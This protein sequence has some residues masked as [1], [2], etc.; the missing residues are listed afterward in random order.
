V[1]EPL[2]TAR[3]SVTGVSVR[4]DRLEAVRD[5]TFDLEPG[6]VTGL[7]G[8]NGAGKTT[9]ID[10]ISGYLPMTGDVRLD[11]RSITADAPHARARR[12]L[13]RTFQSLELFDD[14]SVGENLRLAADNAGHGRRYDDVTH[15]VGSAVALDAMAGELAESDRRMVALARAAAARPQVLLADEPGAGLDPTARDRVGQALRALA[16]G[17]TA[18]LLVDHDTDLVF[19][20][21][22]RVLVLDLGALVA[23][24]PP[25]AVRTDPRV[26]SAY[27]GSTRAAAGA[28]PP[29]ARGDAGPPPVD[30][31][32]LTA[33]YGRGD[34]VHGIDLTITSGEIVALLGPNGAGKTTTLLALSGAL[35]HVGGTGAV[36]GL[37]LGTPAHRSARHG[38]AHVLQDRGVFAGLT[39]RENLRLAQR[40]RDDLD[41][42]V[43]LFPALRAA[44]DRRAGSLSGGEQQMLALA[45]ALVR[46]PR[47]LL[48]DELSLGL[49]PQVVAELLDVVA[50]LARDHGTAVLF[51]EQH[52][53]V[54]LRVAHRALVLSRGTVFDEGPAAAF[55]DEPARLRT[56]Y[57]GRP[58]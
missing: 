54:A 3:L 52:A 21:C 12:G 8:P 31:R 29:A 49:A 48:V 2:V 40:R 50:G 1:A 45:R 24:G 35:R 15:L 37:P 17:G 10:A 22:D 55:R 9:L 16:D 30:V 28:P 39:T 41:T 44:L 51:A 34:V 46:P 23:D 19:D 53:D 38:V 27:L 58:D 6:T 36:A 7:I 11:G 13:V 43:D 14:L 47:V 18:V 56:A 5:V 42:A 4:Y 20:L 33:G 26:L 57:L 32:G 25:A